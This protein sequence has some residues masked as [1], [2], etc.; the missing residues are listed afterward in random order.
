MEACP[1][2]GK[3]LVLGPCFALF[4]DFL[5]RQHFGYNSK[6]RYI[7]LVPDAFYCV[8]QRL[9]KTF[10]LLMLAYLSNTSKPLRSEAFKGA[11]KR[12]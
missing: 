10:W 9:H 8:V 1:K 12:E 4:V 5:L 2:I 6:I 7:N 3:I 11:G